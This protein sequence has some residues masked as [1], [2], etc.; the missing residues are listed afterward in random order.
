MEISIILCSAP[1]LET[2]R[3]LAAGILDENL[4][5]CVSI[6]PGVESHFVWQ[7]NR[8]I[9]AEVLLLIKSIP[10]AYSLLEDY[11]RIHH[12]YECPEIIQLPIANVYHEYAKW[13]G[14][15]FA[16][17]EQNEPLEET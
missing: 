16:N 1:D 9:S 7:G 8:E 15:S 4:A 14:E 2:A 12:P 3:A 6:I 5:A 11:L 10:E 13:V 17:P